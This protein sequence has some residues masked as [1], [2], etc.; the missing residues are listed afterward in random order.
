MSPGTF[1][2]KP[3]A[4]H[5]S[6]PRRDLVPHAVFG[7]LMAAV[8]A[9]D[10]RSVVAGGRTRESLWYLERWILLASLLPSAISDW[11]DLT[12]WRLP[13]LAGALGL[14]TL[15]ACL[16]IHAVASAAG[17]AALTAA[18]MLALRWSS[19]GGLAMGDVQ[20]CALVGLSLGVRRALQIFWFGNILALLALPVMR[21][22]N[23]EKGR[24]VIPLVPWLYVACASVL[25]ISP[26]V[27]HGTQ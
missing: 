22:F 2:I 16:G 14:G 17:G 9:A 19:R 25:L 27:S 3:E 5:G 1:A 15:K 26:P 4:T 23:D 7:V 24:R 8:V 11:Y 6:R 21:E 18:A 20:V 13:T 10:V 12:V